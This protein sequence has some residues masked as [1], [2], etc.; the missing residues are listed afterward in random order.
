[1]MEEANSSD[2]EHGGGKP[3]AGVWTTGGVIMCLESEVNVVV[4]AE[5]GNSEAGNGCETGVGGEGNGGRGVGV[6]LQVGVG[7]WSGGKGVTE[8]DGGRVIC[9]FF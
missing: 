2:M 6:G 4:A 7:G 3:G 9:N 1:M 5:V 8:G